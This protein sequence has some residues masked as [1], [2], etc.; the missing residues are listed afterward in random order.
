MLAEEGGC[1]LE[2][3]VKLL[4]IIVKVLTRVERLASPLCLI[5]LGFYLG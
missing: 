5:E 4:L 3:G 1:G 2:G